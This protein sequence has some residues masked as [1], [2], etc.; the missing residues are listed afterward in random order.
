[1]T[2]PPEGAAVTAAR[3]EVVADGIS[4]RRPEWIER[5]TSADHKTVAVTMIGASL[6]FLVLALVELALMRI[7]LIVP[8]ATLVNPEIFDRLLSA[9]AATAIVLFAIPL[10]LGVIGYVVPLQLGARRV[11]FPRL[12]QLGLWLYLAGGAAIYAS[13]FYTPSEAGI[14]ALPPLS[15]DVFS[16]SNGVDAWILGVGLATL[17]FVCFAINLVV[18]I[19]N[20]RAPGLAWRRLPLFSWAATVIGYLLLVIG[21]VMLAALA[22]L[23]WD[24]HFDGVFLDPG[25][26]GA[27]LL[28][29]HLAWIYL[30][31]AYLIVVLFAAGTISEVLPTFARKPIFSHRAAAASLVAIGA[32]GPLAWMQNMYA[33][34]IPEGWGY[35]AMAA[36]VALAVPVGSLVLNWIATLW[37]GAIRLR[38]PA[39][40][41]LGAAVL[42]VFGLAGE[43]GS[44]VI[45]VGWQLAN[46]TVAQGDTL[47]VLIGGGVLGGF[48]ALHY[49]L[50][51][52]SGRLV[53][54]GIAKAAFGAI[55]AGALLMIVPLQMAGF[56]G[57]PVDVNEFFD[58]ADLALL[59]AIASA[60]AFLLAAGVLAEL[61]NLAR[62]YSRGAPAGHDPWGGATLEWFALSPPPEHNFDAVPDVRSEQ[63]MLDIRDSIAVRTGGG[64]IEPPAAE[65]IP[66]PD[67]EP[68]AAAPAGDDAPG[69]AP[70]A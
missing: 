6:S 52:I 62:S 51:K 59:N 44:S 3:P 9:S 31:G 21:P 4:G 24:R 7:Q 58:R 16:P 2:S 30:T 15:D 69:D 43:L 17:G 13:F 41:A 42:L 18:T 37:G 20:L 46:T 49:W 36:A 28:Y 50:P 35:V 68:A 5:A 26:G 32:I 64:G 14:A 56:Q 47:F 53:G 11:A 12:N 8:E 19:H 48:A 65:A 25:E 39:L 60:G 27:P 54:E 40:Y 22:M 63:P 66:A 10:A 23:I 34:P 67:A 57:Q 38:A 61:A 45:P 29:H 1:V 55:V 33:A 70:V